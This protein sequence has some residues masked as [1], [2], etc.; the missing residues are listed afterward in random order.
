MTRYSWYTTPIQV[1]WCYEFQSLTDSNYND[2][3]FPGDAIPDRGRKLCEN[4]LCPSAKFGKLAKL[5]N[6]IRLSPKIMLKDAAYGLS[7][8]E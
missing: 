5:S 4:R 1:K 2:Q 6:D 8:Q 7:G 3:Y